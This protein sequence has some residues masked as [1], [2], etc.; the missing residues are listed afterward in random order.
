MK[1]AF[2]AQNFCIHLERTRVIKKNEKSTS[3][4]D[5]L[6]DIEF[7]RLKHVSPDYVH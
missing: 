4:N 2:S 6:K 7:E 1:K 3:Y 5:K